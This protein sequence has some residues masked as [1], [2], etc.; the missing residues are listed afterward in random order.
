M[1]NYMCEGAF[2]KKIV[3][4]LDLTPELECIL[5]KIVNGFS[6][7]VPMDSQDIKM[8]IAVEGEMSTLQ[9]HERGCPYALLLSFDHSLLRQSMLN[10][11]AVFD[12]NEPQDFMFSYNKVD[13]TEP[14]VEIAIHHD[15]PLFLEK[16]PREVFGPAADADLAH[17]RRNVFRWIG[18][19]P[20]RCMHRR[21]SF[22]G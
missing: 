11:G 22:V 9:P 2:V 18:Q 15:E 5:N 8:K 14:A 12:L 19:G 4:C 16:I 20:Y 17:N 3:K 21:C 10:A 7:C 13:L 6:P 1:K